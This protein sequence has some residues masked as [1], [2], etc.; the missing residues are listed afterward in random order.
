MFLTK[1]SNLEWVNLPDCNKLTEHGRCS[2]KGDIPC[3][4]VTCQFKITKEEA[5][6]SRYRTMRRLS[7]LGE[8]EQ[9]RIANKYYGGRRVWI[10]PEDNG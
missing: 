2:I 6:A 4:G 1:M 3:T 10:F 9:Q 8:E 5:D 7:S